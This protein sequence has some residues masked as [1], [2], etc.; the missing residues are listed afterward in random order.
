M[1]MV[2]GHHGPHDPGTHHEIPGER[3]GRPY[4]RGQAVGERI[5]LH[6]GAASGRLWGAA[7]AG[8]GG[9]LMALGLTRRSPLARLLGA[10]GG[11][12]LIGVGVAGGSSV[13]ELARRGAGGLAEG[14]WMYLEDSTTVDRPITEV[15]H[16]ARDLGHLPDFMPHVKDVR[17]YDNGRIEW[18]VTGPAGVRM[19]WT[20]RL[21]EDRPQ[22][23]IM[24]R[25]DPDNPFDEVGVVRFEKVSADVTEVIMSVRYRPH[26]GK[27][28][29]LA[30]KVLEGM[31]EGY[32]RGQLRGFKR[33]A[34]ERIVGATV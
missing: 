3:T 27:A 19:T 33:A 2:G 1:H 21:V 34:E 9:M 17:Q 24:W 8:A 15:Y 10:L 31:T 22:E 23:S 14:S 26:G 18:T 4:G 32:L 16:F 6:A 11:G 12:A 25:S 20:G 7:F 29:V 5:G 30:A 28:G 13:R